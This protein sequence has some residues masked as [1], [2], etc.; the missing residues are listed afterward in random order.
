MS[1]TIDRTGAD[2]YFGPTNHVRGTLWERFASDA[3]DGAV[4]MATRL[5]TREIGETITDE[6]VDDSISYR[7]DYAVYE[8]ALHLLLNSDAIPNGQ[9]TAPHFVGVDSQETPPAPRK[10]EDMGVLC[11]EAAGWLARPRR[12]IMLSRG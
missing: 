1:V 9:E 8:Q 10:A 2:T 6:T 7:P 12:R 3:R 11:A 4:A 5:V